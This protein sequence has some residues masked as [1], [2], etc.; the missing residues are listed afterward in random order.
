M[1]KD[2]IQ[3]V[4]IVE[5]TGQTHKLAFRWTLYING[6]LVMHVSYDKHKFQPLLYLTYHRNTF[7]FDLFPKPKDA[8]Y[9]PLE[10]PYALLVFKAYDEEKKEAW[11]D[12]LMQTFDNSE[13]YFKQ[14]Q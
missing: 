7:R 1:K 6:G 4:E 5:R 2:Q 11:F 13:I 3:H 8:L 9:K 14:G 10:T 12:L